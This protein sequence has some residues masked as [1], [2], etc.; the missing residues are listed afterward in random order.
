MN[1]EDATAGTT[2]TL[3]SLDL[4]QTILARPGY[5]DA[6]GLG[7]AGS[8][9]RW[10]AAADAVATGSGCPRIA[11]SLRALSASLPPSGGRCTR[12][13]RAGG[14][15]CRSEGADAMRRTPVAAVAVAAGVAA[16]RRDGRRRSPAVARAGSA[17]AWAR[18]APAAA[19]PAAAVLDVSVQLA[20]R[21]AAGAEAYARAVSDPA[22]S[23]HGRFLTPA[24]YRARFAAS[25][26][27]VARVRSW[28]VRSGLT[29]TAISPTNRSIGV[30]GTVAQLERAFSTRLVR[31][32]HAGTLL[33][34]PARPISL[35]GS[36]AGAIAGVSGLTQSLA[37]R[38]SSTDAP[39][40][41]AFVNAAAVLDV[42]RREARHDAAARRRRGRAVRAVRLRPAAAARRV[43]RLGPRRAGRRPRRHGRRRRC[44]RGADDPLG[45]EHVR[46]PARRR[47]V[48]PRPVRADR[49]APA[50]AT[51][52]TTRSTATSAA[53][54]AGTARRRSTS[55]P[56]T[57]WRPGAN[58]LYVGGRSCDDFDLND[59]VQTIVDRH[60]ADVVTNSYG[61]IGEDLPADDIAANHAT[62][63]QAAIEGIGL[64]F[65][66]GDDGD[67][68]VI[69]GARQV[70]FPASDPFVTA[71]GGTA[72]GI[73]RRGE[74]L[75]ETGWQSGTSTLTSGGWSPTPPGGFLYG[76]G[77]GESQLF[78]AARVPA[79]RRAALDRAVPP[80][81]GRPRGARTSRRSAIRRPAC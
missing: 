55:R 14:V 2:T 73:G 19:E 75:F 26:A 54:R 33:R 61:D 38:A 23:L 18:G 71:V 77:G 79:R 69:D 12:R 6:T 63:V 22:S 9:P 72:I 46:A 64:L 47:R 39:P 68:I 56:S 25:D 48:R 58:V 65:S 1:H 44:V 5:D 34:A 15:A 57:A 28:L 81:P 45:R 30:R 13:S 35:P 4:P 8:R 76:G 21:D 67:E 70:D 50:A 16:A 37:R 10:S 7:V 17:P 53:S 78:R 80:R 11:S 31:Y 43:R 3:R 29:V 51:A 36:V 60:L 41:P 42:L 62:F 59:A 27:T 49:P 52:S 40:P 20:L 24:Q 74:R 32:R 66:S